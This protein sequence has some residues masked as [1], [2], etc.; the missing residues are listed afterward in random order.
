MAL[1]VPFRRWDDPSV[2]IEKGDVLS[3]EEY[4]FAKFVTR[5]QRAFAKGIAESFIVHL[6][7]TG[8]WQKYGL[9]RELISIRFTPPT[10][11]DMYWKQRSV[12]IQTENYVALSSQEEF[13]R[14]TLQRKY[15][16]WTNEEV[17]QNYNALKMEAQ[18]KFIVAK[19]A[20]AGK[21]PEIDLLSS[22]E[23][24]A[25]AGDAPFGGIGEEIPT[26]PP[27]EGAETAGA[28][29]PEVTFE[30]IPAETEEAPA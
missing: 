15:L 24:G 7:L 8:L 2:N 28:T 26:A 1:K 30:E 29:E 23:E 5:L 9:S 10:A 22:S 27:S 25:P 16:G 14:E 19:I 21:E 4:R 6:K 20:E 13:A 11:Y 3:Y 18:R 17:L 12:K